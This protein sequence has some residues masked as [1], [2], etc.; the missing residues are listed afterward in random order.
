VGSACK[1]CPKK[2]ELSPEDQKLVSWLKRSIESHPEIRANLDS[3]GKIAGERPSV[4]IEIGGRI[5]PTREASF[6]SGVTG[7]R[8]IKI[9]ISG[10]GGEGCP[11]ISKQLSKLVH[12]AF[13]TIAG[14]YYRLGV[15]HIRDTLL[16]KRQSSLEE[17]REYNRSAA[18]VGQTSWTEVVYLDSLIAQIQEAR[19]ANQVE[20][21]VLGWNFSKAPMSKDLRNG[22]ISVWGGDDFWKFYPKTPAVGKG[23]E[24]KDG[25][26][27][28]NQFVSLMNMV[29][30]SRERRGMSALYDQVS[31]EV[32]GGEGDMDAAEEIRAA[33][34]V[35][36]ADSRLA[37]LVAM[38]ELPQPVTVS[39]NK[40]KETKTEKVP[41]A[42]ASSECESGAAKLLGILLLGSGIFFV[43]YLSLKKC[44]GA[45]ESD[46]RGTRGGE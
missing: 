29:D 17:L 8:E 37:Y 21:E 4:N 40:V 18:N 23:G 1:P 44:G 24:I 14:D 39:V 12:D 34:R 5:A 9:T 30:A 32:D 45:E 33:A 19:R 25:K 6:P 3:W 10:K 11:V 35:Q 16:K 31:S 28:A 42:A 36:E 26:A 13:K 7:G 20:L 43:L 46:S 41:T 2:Q 27:F 15:A 38:L 22:R